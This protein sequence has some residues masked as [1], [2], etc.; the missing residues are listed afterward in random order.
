ME[1]NVLGFALGLT[2]T[3]LA[4][5][6]HFA[7]G[8]GWTPGEDIADQVLERR[9]ESV[10]ETDFAE[11]MNRSFGAGGGAAAI[12]EAEGGAGELAEGGAGAEAEGATSPADVPDEEAEHFDV[13]YSKE[14]QTVDVAG[15]ETLLEAG[16]DEGW[17]LPYACRQG[18]CV[19]C[20]GR[21][22]DGDARDYVVHDDQQMLE[23][24]ELEQGYVLTCCAYPKDEFTLETSETP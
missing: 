17:D 22:A 15:N 8:T 2:L 5:A 9:A 24:E 3:A 7:R 21:I 13:E 14:G 20:G 23:D 12:P 4:V 16:E 19:S 11:P 1:I 10:P 18:Q 6:M